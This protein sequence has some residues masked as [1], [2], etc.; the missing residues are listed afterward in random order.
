MGAPPAGLLNPNGSINSRASFSI[1]L[2]GNLPP[3]NASFR[4]LF[5]QWGQQLRALHCTRDA[6]RNV[7]GDWYEWLVAICA[8]NYRTEENPEGL[9]ALPLPNIRQ[10]EVS[11]LYR[12]ELYAYIAD[13]REKLTALHVNL[14]TSNPDFVLIDHA[15]MAVPP[16]LTE[17]IQQINEANLDLIG[18]AYQHFVEACS[19]E[20]IRGYMSVKASLAPDRR[21]QIAHE[22][23]LMKALYMHLQ[24]RQWI[25]SPPGIKYY[26]IAA[27]IR[28]RDEAAL[29]TVATHSIITAQ[30][31]PQRAVDA[32]F[33]VDSLAEG[34]RVMAQILA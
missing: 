29:R 24:T 2:G 14:V 21:L 19:F 25:L 4:Q 31:T 28:P 8:W 16:E 7:T 22:G 1:L 17:P 11:R 12:P 32:L 27:Q 15:G 34:Y 20:R 30:S 10:F 33:Q 9:L 6:V 26:G 13:L 3:T 18:N 5:D 23:S